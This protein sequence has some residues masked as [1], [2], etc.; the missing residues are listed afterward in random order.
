MSRKALQATVAQVLPDPR[1][2]FCQEEP[3]LPVCDMYTCRSGKDRTNST[4][5][6]QPYTVK[7]YGS[8]TIN[9][10]D[11]TATLVKET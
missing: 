10:M 1:V 7:Q 4:L 2:Q 9:V 5:V 3:I 8:L 6:S 11:N